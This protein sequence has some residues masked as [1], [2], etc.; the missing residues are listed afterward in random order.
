MKNKLLKYGIKLRF[1]KNRIVDVLKDN[2]GQGA[3]DVA[4]ICI[5]SIVLGSL[6]LAGLY[7]IMDGTVMPSVKEK[8]EGLFNYSG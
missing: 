4:I 7:A 5:L 8:I 3:L 6:V 2:S 1:I